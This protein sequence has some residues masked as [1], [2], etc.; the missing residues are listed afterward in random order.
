MTIKRVQGGALVRDRRAL[1]AQPLQPNRTDPYVAKQA[2]AGGRHF[3]LVNTRGQ[4]R[5]RPAPGY[6]SRTR[7]NVKR[8]GAA[9]GAC[10]HWAFQG[11]H[12]DTCQGLHLLFWSGACTVLPLTAFRPIA[13]PPR[14]RP[15]P[16]QGGFHRTPRSASRFPE[17]PIRLSPAARSRPHCRANL[18]RE[19]YH[20][21]LELKAHLLL[22]VK[23]A[24]ATR[25]AANRGRRNAS[26]STYGLRARQRQSRVREVSARS[27]PALG[28]AGFSGGKDGSA[29]LA[30]IR[31]GTID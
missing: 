20:K 14:Q 21:L 27:R 22:I 4:R 15:V 8:D 13:C 1:T 6:R 30:K 23:A 19:Q 17:P 16:C 3:V 7:Q 18:T 5:V 25:V 26:N 11:F 24:I 31:H 9:V 29:Q 2:G 12:L 28:E 10:T